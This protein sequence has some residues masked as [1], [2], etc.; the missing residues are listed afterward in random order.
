MIFEKLCS[1][2]SW[3]FFK[4]KASRN[5][6]TDVFKAKYERFKELLDSNT[7]MSRIMSDI[8]DKLQGRQI[9]GMSYV[10]SQAARAVFHTL[11]MVKSLDGLSGGKY[12]MLF[13]IV[14]DINAR[15]KDDMARRKESPVAEWILPYSRI[16]RDM[17]DWVGGKSA[18]LG[19]VLNHVGLPVPEGFAITTRAF[20]YFLEA[21][22]L[23]D[24]INKRKMELSAE[25]TE[26]V[27]LVSEEIQRLIIS[28]PVPED[29]RNAILA[30]YDELAERLQGK[31]GAPGPNLSMRSSAIGEDSELSYAGQ[32]L[33]VLNVPR[34]RLC[35]TYSYIIASLYTPRA[36][37][38][39]LSKGIR[40]E[41]IAMSVACLR[42]VDSVSSGVSYSRHPFNLL[43]DHVIITAVPGLGPYAVDGV[44]TPDSYTVSK[45]AGHAI[46]DTKVPCK[47]VQLV[48]N[49]EGG[50]KEIPVPPDAQNRSCLTPE[51]IQTL[52]GYSIK[53]ENH[54]GC[55]QDTEWALDD[56]GNLL[57]LQTRPLRLESCA[58]GEQ[59]T[60]PR[61]EG[62]PLL[63]EDGATAQPGI[64]C[65]PAFQVHSEEDL[66]AFPD[67]AV[68]IARHSS[69]KFVIV[70]Q[71]AQAIVTDSGSVTGHMASLAREFG[72]P[73]ILDARQ[74]VATIPTG[75]EIT[76]DAYSGRIYQGK[77]QELLNLQQP[78]KKTHMMGTPVYQTLKQVSESILPLHL[79]DPKSPAFT[80]ENCTSLH[81]VMRLVHEFS[82]TQMFQISDILSNEGGGAAKLD[83][84]IPLDLF[85]I[86]LG[87]GLVPGTE[88]RQRVTLAS[89]ASVPFRALLEGMT[90]KDIRYHKPRPVELSG[91][92]S[93]MGEQ[94]LSNPHGAERFGDRSY[95]IISDKYI[96]FSSRVGYHYGILDCYCGNTV[97]KNYISFSFK[98]GAADDTRRSRR[99][100]SIGMILKNLDFSVECVADRVDAKFQK[101]EASVIL[102]KLDHVGKLLIFTRQMDMLM[103]SEGAVERMANCFLEGNY[104]LE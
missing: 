28:A 8:E 27:T 16:G 15:I 58:T 54:Y 100:R 12:V 33:S 4:P 20:Q 96:N 5:D 89:V 61:I 59:A 38:Y 76:V 3:K 65:G 70:M 30:A 73:T 78:P 87:G 88:C 97:N 14:E 52:T 91:F 48:T 50:L 104:H 23:V 90:H 2:R 24:E 7:E 72:I 19:E 17:V 60:T 6:L 94:M 26:S 11:R 103:T 39:R 71:K 102:E 44:I 68:L 79:Y 101:Y 67:G 31:G 47:P 62:Y 81:D 35:Q 13:R 32:Y 86:D 92:L 51:Q 99:A 85:I 45:E 77:V 66:S 69:P 55:P 46:L 10:R 9:F 42:M 53:L 63:V 56:Q 80:P 36:I 93:V 83:A 57:V 22:D 84:P 74:A 21:N 64:G 49:P 37:S 25:D 41:D 75:T 18:N 1:L 43:E 34:Q 82:Y 29:L 40:D 98:G 95:A